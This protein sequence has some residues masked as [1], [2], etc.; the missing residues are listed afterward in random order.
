MSAA[1]QNRPVFIAFR[2]TLG[3]TSWSVMNLTTLVQAG[4]QGPGLLSLAMWTS[5]GHVTDDAFESGG[6]S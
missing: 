4:L 1:A 2:P 3:G 6:S 5:F